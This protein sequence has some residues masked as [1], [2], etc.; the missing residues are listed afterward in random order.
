[1]TEMY[2]YCLVVKKYGKVSAKF[3]LGKSMVIEKVEL[4][5]YFLFLARLNS[6]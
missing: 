4:L 3:L 2:D 5:S 6:Y 1:M